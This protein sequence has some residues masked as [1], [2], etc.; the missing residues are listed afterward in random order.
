MSPL[1]RWQKELDATI[2]DVIVSLRPTEG[3]AAEQF[4]GQCYK[5]VAVVG[6]VTSCF[7]RYEDGRLAREAFCAAC[8]AKAELDVLERIGPMGLM[9]VMTSEPIP[10]STG[11]FHTTDDRY[12]ANEADRRAHQKLLDERAERHAAR[13][14][15]R[16]GEG[17]VA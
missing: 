9:D 1:R 7:I 3:P 14:R 5:L 6:P 11:S 15:A 8:L 10:G 2:T 12:F 17:E 16:L 13:V 4:C